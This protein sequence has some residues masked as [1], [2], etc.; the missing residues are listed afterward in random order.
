MPCGQ[1]YEYN[2]LVD[3]QILPYYNEKTKNEVSTL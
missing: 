3:A 2:K 1:Y